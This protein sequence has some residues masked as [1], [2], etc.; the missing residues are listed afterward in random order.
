MDVA[1]RLANKVCFISG[2]ARGIGAGIARAMVAQGGT[3]YIGDRDAGGAALT[4]SEIGATA[5]HMDVTSEADWARLADQIGQDHD[6]LDVFV[7][8]AGL[9]RVSSLQKLSVADLRAVM[10]VN[11]EGPMIGCRTLL[12]LLIESGKRGPSASVINIASAA[13]LIGQPDLAAYS[14]SKAAIGHLSKV[15]AIEWPHHGYAIR[16]NSIYPGCII[17]PMLELAVSGWVENGILDEASAWNTM[18]ALSPMN[19][20]GEVADIAM[21]AV[22]LAS[23]ES[24]FITGIDLIIDGGWT[25]R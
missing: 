8:N 24:K 1:G 21:G 4:A 6:R 16:V 7:N 10:S 11:L 15:L 13:G 14:V 17:T 3:V 23:D 9:E 5:V 12:P 20:I 2:A 22:Y 25:A 19:Q 18:R